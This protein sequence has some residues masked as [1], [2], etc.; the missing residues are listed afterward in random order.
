MP[1]GTTATPAA[2]SSSTADG[3]V[4]STFSAITSLNRSGCTGS[5]ARSASSSASAG[6]QPMPTAPHGRDRLRFTVDTSLGVLRARAGRTLTSLRGH[7]AS[8]IV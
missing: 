4:R 5:A 3:T 1:C 2:T 6:R 7:E 8:S